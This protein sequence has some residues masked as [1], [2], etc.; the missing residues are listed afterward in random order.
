MY[1]H[2]LIA[3]DGSQPSARALAHGLAPAPVA[4]TRPTISWPGMIGRRGAS[5]SSLHSQHSRNG[6]H[7][8]E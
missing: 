8:L 5:G 7:G 3:T 6:L 4:S 2:L 1:K